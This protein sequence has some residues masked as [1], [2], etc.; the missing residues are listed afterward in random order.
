MHTTDFTLPTHGVQTVPFWLLKNCCFMLCMFWICLHMFSVFTVHVHMNM[1]SGVKP[2]CI[3]LFVGVKC[4]LLHTNE[5]FSP[6]LCLGFQDK[7]A[8]ISILQVPS[9][10]LWYAKQSHYVCFVSPSVFTFEKCSHLHVSNYYVF[11]HHFTSCIASV[12]VALHAR[13]SFQLILSDE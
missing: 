5:H 7:C 10:I 2:H 8:Y 4:F 9:F 12:Y 11:T 13:I 6:S 3:Y 1:S